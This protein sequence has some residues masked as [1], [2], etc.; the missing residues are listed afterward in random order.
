M[1]IKTGLELAA[2]CFRKYGRI[3]LF[4]ILT[5][6]E[7]FGFARQALEFQAVDY[8]VKLE[9]NPESLAQSVKK[10]MNIL[11]DFR[12]TSV[13]GIAAGRSRLQGLR[14]K[15]FL[16]LFNG[17]FEDRKTFTAEMEEL[18]LQFS[19]SAITVL[20]TEIEI[21]E[22]I[23]ASDK[24]FQVLYTS[25]MQMVWEK[26]EKLFPC[27][28]AAL[29]ARHFS[30]VFCLADPEAHREL[31]ERE[32][33][34][35]IDMVHSYF[36]V[37]IRMAMGFPVEDPF[38]LDESYLAAQQVFR[39]TT[40]ERPIAF[41][42]ERFD[43]ERRLNYKQQLVANMQEYIRHNLDKR[44]SLHDLA[45][46]FNFSPNYLSQLFT[47]YAG[48]GIVEYITAERISAAKEML[49][50]RTR[51]IYEIAEKLGYESAFYFSKVFKKAE[52]ISPREFLR[53]MDKG[54]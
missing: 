35:T 30:V 51:P 52:G 5:S 9:L 22:L 50:K 37:H 46:I 43:S 24:K 41:F 40:R 49:K 34:K 21:P 23:H 14:E 38:N 33:Q 27:Y 53:Q 7:E 44:L 8:L 31:L 39:E 42:G 16:K 20:T 2:E 10:A 19:G 47:K 25:T 3:P 4:I 1:P 15:F 13:S 36:N 18:D 54:E 45:A 6:Y 17:L 26:L 28:F 12:G 48:E 11:E 32:L 29:D